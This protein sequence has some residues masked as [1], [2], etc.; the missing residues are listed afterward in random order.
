LR[1]P[2][3]CTTANSFGKIFTARMSRNAGRL[4]VEINHACPFGAWSRQGGD[5]AQPLDCGSPLPL[6]SVGGKAP[7]DW[8]TPKFTDPSLTTCLMG[9]EATMSRLALN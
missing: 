2:S 7:E 3:N 9:M 4:S 8:R 1:N 5:R 6:W